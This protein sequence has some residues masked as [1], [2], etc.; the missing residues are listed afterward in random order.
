[1]RVAGDLWFGLFTTVETEVRRRLSSTANAFDELLIEILGQGQSAYREYRAAACNPTQLNP[2]S[3]SQVAMAGLLLGCCAGDESRAFAGILD[4]GLKKVKLKRPAA[5]MPGF[6]NDWK[7]L[8]GAAVGIGAA[9][10]LSCDGDWT[11]H[12]SYVL[13]AL[14]ELPESDMTSAVMVAFS[15]KQLGDQRPV[16]TAARNIPDLTMTDLISVVW[17]H[18]V[19]L[20]LSIEEECSWAALQAELVGM[21]VADLS[22]H[23]LSLLLI[24]LKD[25]WA[26]GWAVHR[27]QGIEFVKA[28][29]RGFLPCAKRDIKT[30]LIRNEADVQ[31]IVWTMLRP[32]FPDLVDEDYLPKFGAKNY[33][34]DFG[35]PSLRLLIEAK[36]VS[37]SKTVAEIQDEV[38]AD[39]IGYRESTSEYTAILFFVYDTRGEL[40]A[41]SELHRVIK[42]QQGVADFIAVVGPLPRVCGK[43]TKSRNR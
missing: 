20:P 18:H 42:E 1:M 10:K 32:T 31:R 26:C 4:A 25:T 23:E 33:R 22:F 35:I 8:L 14:D 21:R 7:L 24:V 12:R 34:A 29:L 39:I 28:T 9:I 30:E 40:T 19:G 16:T 36:Y 17:A 3:D 43:I 41:H 6:A 5:G 15:R 27:A 37:A 13:N 2:Y 38:Q 11:A